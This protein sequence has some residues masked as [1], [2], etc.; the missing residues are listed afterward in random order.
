MNNHSGFSR[1]ARDLLELCELQFQLLSVDSQ[2][3]RRKATRAMQLTVIS[4]ALG[5]SALTTS[6]IGCSFLVHELAGWTPGA[7]LASVAA[8]SFVVVA[9]L[10]WAASRA[11]ATA[12]AALQETK[13]E[14][15]ENLKWLKAVLIR[16]ETS[17][18]NQLRAESF[19]DRNPSCN[20]DANGSHP[21]QSAL[22]NER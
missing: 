20:P 1:V 13:S 15:I 19:P 21:F 10:L 14:F 12:T 4:I 3:A 11:T 5:G 16:P 8:A 17:P 18:R 9:G 7:S 22:Y 2:E 6:M